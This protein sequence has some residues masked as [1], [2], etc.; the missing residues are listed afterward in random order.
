MHYRLIRISK[1]IDVNQ[2]HKLFPFYLNAF[3]LE[4]DDTKQLSRWDSPGNK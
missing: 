2:E 4:P 1:I 3:N